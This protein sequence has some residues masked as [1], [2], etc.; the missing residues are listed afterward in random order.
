MLV[1]TDVVGT[2][3]VELGKL[4]VAEHV[5]VI[6]LEAGAAG[7]LSTVLR[8]HTAVKQSKSLRGRVRRWGRREQPTVDPGS[9]TA[10]L[11]ALQ[12]AQTQHHDGDEQ[13]DEHSEYDNH[14]EP[15]ERPCSLVFIVTLPMRRSVVKLSAYA[16]EAKPPR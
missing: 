15:H 10:V 16:S 7:R 9:A 1:M 14:G 5:L 13:H 8:R 2:D 11:V 4:G 6:W 3:H 12:F